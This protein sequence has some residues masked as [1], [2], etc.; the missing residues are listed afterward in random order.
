M[1]FKLELENFHSFRDKQV[2]DLRV[3]ANAPDD[4]NRLANCFSGSAVRVPKVITVFGPNGSGKSNLLRALSF[5]AWFVSDS[6]GSKRN[7]RLPFEPF[8]DQ[9]SLNRPTTLKVWFSAPDFIESSDRIDSVKRPFCYEL[10]INNEKNKNLVLKEAVFF[11]PT[12][13]N[14]KT[15]LFHRNQDGKVVSAKAFK[16]GGYMPVLGKI[17]KPCTSV[18]STLANIEHPVAAAVSELMRRVGSNIFIQKLDVEERDV[19]Q[20]YR[21]NP[22]MAAQFD[23]DVRRLDMGIHSVKL[24]SRDSGSWGQFHHEHLCQPVDPLYE[25]HGTRQLFKLYPLINEVINDGS[26]AI[27]DELD[28]ATHPMIVS[29]IIDW[30]Y[31]SERNPHDAQL[32]TSC[33]ATSLL[34][35]LSKDEIIFCE[36]THKGSTDAYGLTEIQSVRRDENFYRKYLGGYYGALPKVG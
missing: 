4:S 24:N 31:N 22:N 11:W 33:H 8:Y 36:K 29:Q 20:V 1:I 9:V 14:R 5:V 2:I 19:A 6:F 32:W 21:N 25:S 23:R 35:E 3:P 18:I 30:F 27:I 16:L 28:S 34:E 12:K 17:L 26:I 7:E 10:V 15:C 13:S